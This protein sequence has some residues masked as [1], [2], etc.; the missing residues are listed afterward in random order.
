ML[1]LPEATR[2]F[3]SEQDPLD[4]TA[5]PEPYNNNQTAPCIAEFGFFRVFVRERLKFQVVTS[6]AEFSRASESQVAFPQQD[7]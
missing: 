3:L 2:F 4:L 7:T 1:G 5:S 6:I